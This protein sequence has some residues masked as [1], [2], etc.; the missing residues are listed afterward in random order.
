MALIRPK[1]YQVLLTPLVAKNTYGTEQD[2]TLNVDLEDFVK[3]GGIS[4][5]KREIDNGDFEVG[6]FV[7]GSINLT[8]IN[9]DGRFSDPSDSRTL[10]RYT[11]DKARITV[12]FYDGTS[13]TAD[14]SFRGLID[15]R[16]TKMNF[17]KNEV[18]FKLS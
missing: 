11:R 8:C 1:G 16:A 9:T 5:I 7:F 18:K 3:N 14:S 12:N 13:N 6:V 2:I 10:F 17:G 4:T 15:D